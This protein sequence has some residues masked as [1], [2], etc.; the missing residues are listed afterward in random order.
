MIREEYTRQF[1]KTRMCRFFAHSKCHK[2]AE[3]SHAHSRAELLERP[4]L[5]KTSLCRHW[6][7]TGS[8]DKADKCPYAHGEEQLRPRSSLEGRVNSSSSSESAPTDAMCANE[9][10][11]F[12]GASLSRAPTRSSTLDGLGSEWLDNTKISPKLGDNNCQEWQAPSSWFRYD[13]PYVSSASEFAFPV[14]KRTWTEDENS[15]RFVWQD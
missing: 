11:S 15:P 4:D 14:V 6:S 2:G 8:C 12:V 7:S 9:L 13:Q 10:N 5:R 1:L 3:C